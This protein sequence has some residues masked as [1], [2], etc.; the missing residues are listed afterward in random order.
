MRANPRR[1]LV[2]EDD[3]GIR[4]YVR[5]RLTGL[6][7]DVHVARNGEDALARIHELRPAALVLDINMP[8]ADGFQVMRQIGTR[9]PTLVISARSNQDDIVLAL[10]LGAKDY[11]TKPFTEG[12]L[13]ARVGRL[14]R[15]AAGSP[16]AQSTVILD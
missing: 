16:R 12:Q 11:L 14:M 6:G 15:W 2:A 10:S 3:P 1:I 5:E 4:E 9:I 7:Y 8:G 13:A